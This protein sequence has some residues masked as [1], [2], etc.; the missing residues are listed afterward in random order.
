MPLDFRIKAAVHVAVTSTLCLA[1]AQDASLAPT[2]SRVAPAFSVQNTDVQLLA[3][4]AGDL[5]AYMRALNEM[6]S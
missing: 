4:P 1:C 2:D 5:G 6:N 3:A